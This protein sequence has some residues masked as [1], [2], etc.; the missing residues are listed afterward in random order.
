MKLF[1]VSHLFTILA[2]YNFDI[3]KQILIISCSL[4]VTDQILISNTSV[5][6]KV[7]NQT[8]LYFSISLLQ[9]FYTIQQ[10]TQNPNTVWCFAKKH[11][12]KLSCHRRMMQHK[13]S[14]KILQN[15]AHNVRQIAFEKPGNTW[16]TFKVIQGHRKRHDSIGFI[17]FPISGL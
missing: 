16:M 8:V 3:Y 2:C 1:S 14:V 12:Q 11:I 7:R 6:E 10:K 9:R 4:S 15:A 17:E 13:V 5:I